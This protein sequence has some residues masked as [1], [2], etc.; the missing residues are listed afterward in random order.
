MK[1]YVFV[2]LVLAVSSFAQP[3]IVDHT[4]TDLSTIPQNYIDAI[5][6]S[7]YVFHY[8][9]RSHGSQLVTGIENLENQNSLYN[10]DIAYLSMPNANNA[11][12]M[13]Y[14]MLENDYVYPEDYWA[15]PDGLNTLR[16]LLNDHPN[17]R[18]S[19]WT[20]CG[21]HHDYSQEQVQG[22]LNQLDALASEFPNVTIIYMTGNAQYEG[23]PWAGRNTFE[24][25]Q[26]IR[27]YCESHNKI[28][29]DFFDLD[30]WYQGN[31]AILTTDY[32]GETVSFPY[33]HHHYEG[34][35]AGHTTFEN[36][37]QKGVA[38]WWMMARLYGW[39]GPQGTKVRNL[40]P[41]TSALIQAFPNPFNPQTTLRIDCP[42]SGLV[43]VRVYDVRGQSVETSIQNVSMEQGVQNLIWNGD[44]LPSGLY[45]VQ[46]YG[47]DWSACIKVIL[48]R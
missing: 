13:W 48:L 41:E 37:N 20:W 9:S 19:M 18:Y 7:P 26:Q 36:C 6:A 30:S 4:C 21:E 42:A 43:S 25:C 1:R 40:T 39:S 46:V 45:Y 29:Y 44:G 31:Q 47:M 17:I 22:Y 3:I 27:T 12:G 11:F 23:D 38:L 32:Y 10:I 8:A 2:A 28:L 24:R 16:K 14:G 34:D 33:Q 5:K 35:E 15:S